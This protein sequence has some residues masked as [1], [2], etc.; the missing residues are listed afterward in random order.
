MVAWDVPLPLP[1]LVPD[2]PVEELPVEEDVEEDVPLTACAAAVEEEARAP[3][4]ARPATA[5]EAA[6]EPPTRVRRSLPARRRAPS[7]SRPVRWA[8]SGAADDGE[9][10]VMGRPCAPMLC[11]G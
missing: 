11:S 4:P 9:G 7:R 2:V 6:I 8:E 10:V 3:E 5:R 1:R